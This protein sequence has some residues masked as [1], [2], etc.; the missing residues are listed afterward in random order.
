MPIYQV[1]L[2]GCAAALENTLDSGK[3]DFIRNSELRELVIRWRKMSNEYS[4]KQ[5]EI[6]Q[7]KASN[8]GR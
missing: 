2:G 7:K 3:S 4:K 6:D 5:A 1:P 8:V